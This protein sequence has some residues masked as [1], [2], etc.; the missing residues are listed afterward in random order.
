MTDGAVRGNGTAQPT[1]SEGGPVARFRELDGLR[2]IAALGVVVYHFTTYTSAFTQFEPRRV[3]PA[4]WWGEYGVQLFFLISGFVILM[5]ARRAR[6]VTDFAI[7]RASRLYPVY[8]LALAVSLTLSLVFPL[9][10]SGIGWADRIANVTMVQRFLLFDNVDPVYWTLAVE[11]QFYIILALLILVT[12]SR[13]TDRVVLSLCV[14][15]LIVAAA[16]AIVLRPH[17]FGVNPQL[18]ETPFKIVNNLLLVEHGPLFVA[19]MLCYLARSSRRYLPLAIAALVLAPGI[20][21][22][23]RGAEHAGITLVVAALFGVVALRPRTALLTAAPVQF[24]GR[25]SYSL[26]VCHLSIGLTVMYLLDGWI[27][28]D[29]AAVAALVAVTGAAMLYHRVGEVQGTNAMKRFLRTCFSRGERTG[30]A[31]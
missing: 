2:G 26:Y 11:M 17:T 31:V 15:W 1:F 18:V 22:I 25:L 24:Y 3:W 20:L 8:W 27:G 4:V 16:A 29:L 7:S 12:R 23:V 19:G 5:S 6:T 30:V 14:G 28:Y 9:P 13:L 21:W 10:G